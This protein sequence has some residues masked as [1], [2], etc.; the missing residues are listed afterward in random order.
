MKSYKGGC[1]CGN[2]WYTFDTSVALDRL[3]LR[4]CMCSFC[5][6]HGARNVSDPQGRIRIDVRNREKLVRYRFGLKTADFL[7]CANCGVYVGALLPA[8]SQGWF[9]VNANTFREPPPLDAAVHPFEYDG[10][11]VGNR[12]DRRRTDWTPVASLSI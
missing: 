8:G 7:L 3:E 10:E 1:H 12:V 6:A 4:A 11:D 9:T 5:R 2:L